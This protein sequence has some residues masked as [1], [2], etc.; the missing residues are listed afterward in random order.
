MQGMANGVRKGHAHQ[1]AFQ[2]YMTFNKCQKAALHAAQRH[3][4]TPVVRDNWGAHLLRANKEGW[5]VPK[6]RYAWV[7]RMSPNSAV[8]KGALCSVSSKTLLENN[9]YSDFIRGVV[10]FT[11]YFK[12]EFFLSSVIQFKAHQAHWSSE[13]MIHFHKWKLMQTLKNEQFSLLLQL[14]ASIFK[15]VII[16][17]NYYLQLIQMIPNSLKSWSYIFWIYSKNSKSK[18][19]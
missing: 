18:T 13:I 16:I 12:V 11:F 15:C 9:L 6:G 10:H 17:V 3:L 1:M 2:S 19:P 4:G 5:L 14:S 8:I 7:K